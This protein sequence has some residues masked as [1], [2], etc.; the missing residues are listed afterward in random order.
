MFSS[1]TLKMERR[2]K[3]NWIESHFIFKWFSLT[4]H[5]LFD[6]NFHKMSQCLLPR[7]SFNFHWVMTKSMRLYDGKGNFHCYIRIICRAKWRRRT[8]GIRMT[9][10]KIWVRLLLIIEAVFWKRALKY[11]PQELCHH[12]LNYCLAIIISHFYWVFS[13]PWK[14]VCE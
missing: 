8:R 10:I 2:P 1:K 5:W 4:L 3:V 13:C 12:T 9:W 7:F 6:E 14:F 11:I